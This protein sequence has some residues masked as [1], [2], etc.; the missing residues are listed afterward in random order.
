M[1]ISKNGPYGHPNGKI[2]KLVHYMLKGQPVTR[3]VG[4]RTKSSQKQLVN[5]QAMAVTMGFS[6]PESVLKFINIGFE[7]EARGTVK[8]PHNLA[9]SYNKKFALKGEYPNLKID[10]SKAMVSQ[11]SLAAPRDTKL[12]KTAAGLELSWDSSPL[13][14]GNHEDDIAMILL[15]YPGL[16]DASSYLNAAKREDGKHFVKLNES[17]SDQPIEVYMCFKSADGKEISNSVYFGNL[18]GEAE[19]AEERHQKKKYEALKTRFDQV[20]A[21]YLAYIELSGNAIV[22]TKAFRNLETEYLALKSKLD[23]L[24]GKPS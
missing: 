5:C 13:E 23:N 10:Y 3:M 20:A 9:T 7:L 12:V 15:C 11:G 22:V 14:T 21:S 4:R 24:P 2:G 16:E 6:R 18:N 1:A 17:L 19:T 8:N